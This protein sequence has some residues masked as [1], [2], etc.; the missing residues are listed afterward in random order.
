MRECEEAQ[1]HKADRER[2]RERAQR[3][4]ED[5]PDAIRRRKYPRCTQ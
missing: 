2:E 4:K 3:A 5:E 1:A